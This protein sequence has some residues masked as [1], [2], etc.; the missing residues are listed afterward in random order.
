MEKQKKRFGIRVRITVT[1]LLAQV[2]AFTAMFLLINGLVSSSS[3]E[4]AVNNM[5]TAAR[6]RSEIIENYISSTED[7]LTAYLK[8][9]QIR[10]AQKS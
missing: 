5:Q 3:Y 1:V 4:N 10:S 8:A 6:D 2:I 9:Q 7:T